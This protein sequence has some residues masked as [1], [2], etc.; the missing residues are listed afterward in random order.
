MPIV[1]QLEDNKVALKIM[2]CSRC[3]GNHDRLIF[4]P[5]TRPNDSW[6][7]W[8]MC[9]TLSEPL[10][11]RFGGGSVQ[12]TEVVP[13]QVA[14]VAVVGEQ[15][16]PLEGLGAGDQVDKH[17]LEAVEGEPHQSE[18]KKPAKPRRTIPGTGTERKGS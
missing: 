13:N 6:S 8:C 3:G 18:T 12:P 4:Q 11:L 5:F 17:P 7:H 15:T 2:L 16:N 14:G 9:P 10:M 1:E